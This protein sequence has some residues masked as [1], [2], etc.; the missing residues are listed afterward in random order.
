M[1]LELPPALAGDDN[2]V[3]ANSEGVMKVL[4]VTG[5]VAVG[6]VAVGAGLWLKD[7]LTSAAGADEQTNLGIRV[8]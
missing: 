5:G 1:G 6:A 7:K 3:E 2:E 8:A 4:R